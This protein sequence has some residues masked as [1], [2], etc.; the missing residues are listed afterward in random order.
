MSPLSVRE[1]MD[2]DFLK[3]ERSDTLKEAASR[4]LE[5]ESDFLVVVLDERA[6]GFL[7]AHDII[8]KSFDSLEG[9]RVADVMSKEIISIDGSASID[10]TV[11]LMMEKHIHHILVMEGGD[12][13]GVLYDLD[14]IKLVGEKTLFRAK[15][16]REI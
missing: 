1:I 14:I 11:N 6:I 16:A 8:T 15:E 2:R 9:K 12:V 13:I 5:A 4:M 10:K 7:S 3:I